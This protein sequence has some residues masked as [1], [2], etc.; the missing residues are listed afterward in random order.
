MAHV[1]ELKLDNTQLIRDCLY[2]QEIWTKNALIQATGLSNGSAT[3]ILK[4][5]TATHEVNYIGDGP[6]TGGRKSKCYQL[7]RD[8]QHIGYL[9]CIQNDSHASL[10]YGICDLFAQVIYQQQ[11]D[12]TVLF[13]EHLLEAAKKLIKED[14]LISVICVSIPGVSIQGEVIICDCEALI[15]HP[16]GKHLEDHTNRP[17]IIEND[18]NVACIGFASEH[19]EVAHLCFLYQPR[20][21][22]VGCGMMINHQLYNG[23]THFAGELRYLPVYSHQKQDVLLKEDPVKLLKMQLESLNAVINPT[24]IGVCSDQ[25]E[26][27]S[28][29]TLTKDIL[30]DHKPQVI[31]VT[32]F[33]DLIL[34]GLYS[35]GRKTIKGGKHGQ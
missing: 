26:H 30:I 5:L 18:V 6:S 10:I 8:Y 12:F 3:N 4:E 25:I 23:A 15:H 7:N 22:Y 27:L 2:D 29:D 21:A 24:L 33:Q 34:K 14:P 9:I 11:R 1:G 28:A 16:I 19:P 35:I 32:H 17:C 20:V 13:E 31:I